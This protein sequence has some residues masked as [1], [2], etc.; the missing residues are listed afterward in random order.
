MSQPKHAMEANLGQSASFRPGAY[1]VRPRL[2]LDSRYTNPCRNPFVGIVFAE[3]LNQLATLLRGSY[4]GAT[5]FEYS[6]MRP[7][8]GVLVTLVLD[9]ADAT[10]GV[11]GGPAESVVVR[12]VSL[13]DDFADQ[14]VGITTTLSRIYQ[15]DGRHWLP[16]PDDLVLEESQEHWSL[17]STDETAARQLLSFDRMLQAHALMTPAEKAALATWESR[18]VIG[19]GALGTTDWPGWPALI[20]RLSN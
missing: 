7:D 15:A 9:A 5:Q 6:P 11:V 14:D 3:S 1:V 4:Y 16:I 12:P 18:F 19:D 20:A 10:H 2:D 17:P 8:D 13:E